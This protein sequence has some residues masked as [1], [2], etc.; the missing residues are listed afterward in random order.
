MKVTLDKNAFMPTKAHNTDAGYDLYLPTQKD[1]EGVTIKAGQTLVID[2]G[3][4]IQ[5]PEGCAAVCMNKSG[6]SVKHGIESVL[7][8][9]DSGY[10]GAIKVKLRNTS[11]KDYT[12]YGGEKISQLVIFPICTE[13]LELTDKLED[14][15]RGS[16]G[17]GS[18]GRR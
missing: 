1:R 12:F 11:D 18:T 5:L 8:L 10:T 6:L 3:V 17:F 16:H 13:G 7:G 9:I 14:T 15:E 4:H 2:T